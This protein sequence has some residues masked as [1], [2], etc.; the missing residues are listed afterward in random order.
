MNN[1]DKLNIAYVCSE[2]VPFIKTGGLADVSNALPAALAKAGH[3]VRIFMPLYRGMQPGSEPIESH[4]DATRMTFHDAGRE[5]RVSILETTLT[6]GDVPVYFFACPELFEEGE[7]Y[8]ADEL[9]PLRFSI[10]SRAAIELCQRLSF[11]P[12]VFH[13]HDWHAALLPLYLKTTYEW[14]RFFSDTRSLLTIHNIGYQGIFSSDWVGR[15]G[16]EGGAHLF[17]HRDFAEGRINFLKTG[18]LYADRVSTVSPTYAREIRDS[19][20][21]MGLQEW[22][23]AR[24][25]GI[26]GILNGID[27]EV[28]N[29][30]L[31][32]L[33]PCRFSARNL[34][35]KGK[36]KKALIAETGLPYDPKAPLFGWIGRLTPQK[37]LDR[38]MEVLPDWVPAH[39]GR[40]IVLG[41]GEERYE[42]FWFEM[43]MAFPEKVRFFRGYN[44]SLAHQI[45]A[46]SDVFIMP[47][48]YEPC[49]LNQMYSQAY[50]TVPIVRRTGGL[51]DSVEPIA[52]DGESGTG[53][54]F[55]HDD[56]AGFRWAL[57]Q[58]DR[59]YRNKK[60][61]R[62]L[63]LRGM[64]Q[65]FSWARQ[66]SRYVDLYRSM[67]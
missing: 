32:T 26:A 5:Y 9:E 39:D 46:G 60:F 51:A 13:V 2:A 55:D 4:T 19:A 16:F 45:E 53:I 61:W 17:E 6:G 23:L 18:I 12:D 54:V 52:A 8:Q 66:A 57:D 38:A 15:L 64:S 37:G 44:E 25:E 41:S 30:A 3:D 47:S 62:S 63:R 35:A 36:C 43:Q 22:L 31:D 11:R 1:S 7:I 42:S 27:T 24:K 10:L 28:W 14:D 56:A 20:L 33:I 40:W 65:D 59:L 29:P 58:A 48:R 67:R 34:P 49:G 21:G 50:G